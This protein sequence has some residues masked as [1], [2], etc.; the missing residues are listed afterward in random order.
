MILRKSEPSATRASANAIASAI[1]SAMAH[2]YG[3]SV[4]TELCARAVRGALPF[5]ISSVTFCNGSMMLELARLRV[6]P[7]LLRNRAVGPLFA[8]LATYR[9]FRLQMR[10]ILAKP[11]AVGERELELHWWLM[12]NGNG[13]ER[14]AGRSRTWACP[15]TSCGREKTPSRFPKSPGA[16]P[17]R[18]AP[19][20]RG[21]TSWGTTRCGKTRAPGPRPSTRRSA[22]DRA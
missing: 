4:A 13:R 3:T 15:S 11:D 14:M 7:Q 6:S 18:L 2:D 1:R 21:S 9:M 20:W 19:R 5:R 16:S 10:R 12:T 17:R 8:R 22:A